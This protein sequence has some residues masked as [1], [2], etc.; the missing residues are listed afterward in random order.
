MKASPKGKELEMKKFGTR[1]EPVKTALL[2]IL[3][4]LSLCMVSMHFAI[5]KG[6]NENTSSALDNIENMGSVIST[7][8][9][10]LS[11]LPVI[12]ETV[13]IKNSMG[14]ISAIS[15]G[16]HYMREVYSLLRS[17]I[18]YILGQNCIAETAEDDVF[19]KLLDSNGFI[20][21]GYHTP[22]PASLLFIHAKDN[23]DSDS[24]LPIGNLTDSLY[25]KE[26]IIFPENGAGDMTYAAARLGNGEAVLFLVKNEPTEELVRI[27]DFDIYKKAA[28][29]FPARFYGKSSNILASSIVYTTLPSNVKISVSE[30]GFTRESKELMASLAE[31]FNINPDKT[32]SYFDTS[33]DG[34]VYTATHGTLTF[35][36]KLISYTTENNKSG[37]ALEYFSG[38]SGTEPHSLC[39]ILACAEQIINSLTSDQ[40]LSEF[41]GN[42]AELL[43]T[44][45]YRDNGK[46]VVEYGYFYDNIKISDLERAVRLE[47]N[48]ER[49]SGISII[50]AKIRAEKG[51]ESKALSPA[52]V[53]SVIE[54]KAENSSF[55]TIINKYK[56]E[57]GEQGFYASEWIPSEIK[58]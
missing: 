33:K 14:D 27:T 50:P 29:M 28:A 34:T 53:L 20:Y 40:E 7:A 31:L 41:F 57:N 2:V 49:L 45:L 48:E 54:E 52:I 5:L 18:A 12:P 22:L 55:F 6:K 38:K 19:D 26:L 8:Y 17:D 24:S 9:V 47:M 21:I 23:I 11:E 58:K 42:E 10:S 13:A 43:L 4:L 35:T 15:S 37:I 51:N 16:I 36:E 25:I 56:K 3:F 1:I 30:E 46:I 39:D 32:G 44:A